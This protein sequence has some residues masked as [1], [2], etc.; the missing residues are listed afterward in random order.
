[1]LIGGAERCVLLCYFKKLSDD[2]VSSI[3]CKTVKL[4]LLP[5]VLPVFQS[6][7]IENASETFSVEIGLAFLLLKEITGLLLW[8]CYSYGLLF[9]SIS[10]KFWFGLCDTAL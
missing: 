2:T 4:S 5:P 3:K 6:L 10:C 7:V 9:L 8:Y 1:M